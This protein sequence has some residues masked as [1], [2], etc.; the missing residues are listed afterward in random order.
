MQSLIKIEWLKIKKYPAFWWM[1]IIVALTYPG[2]NYMFHNIYE[3]II[4]R[5][6]MAG[7]VAKFLLGNPFSF[8]DAWHSVA[9]FSSFFVIVPALLII[10]LVSNEYTYKTHRQ[11][12]IDGWSRSQFINAKMIDVFIISFIVTLSFTIV[13]AIFGFYFSDAVRVTRWAE[14]LQYIPLFFLQ[15]FAQLSWAF[16][17]AFLIKRA[18]IALGI[19]VFYSLIIE[20]I[21]KGYF[22]FREWGV[23]E[24]F[25]FEISNRLLPMP[26]FLGKIDAASNEAY[27]KTLV[28]INWHILYTL[29][30]TSAI[31]WLCY[32]INK[33]RDL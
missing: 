26:N 17:L 5:K 3:Q 23:R 18:F 14:E 9:Y 11:N 4:G 30:L 13:A 20:N 31:W 16:L 2:I 27:K 8:P 19:F 24:F 6:D 7:N 12:I 28:D 32:A 10:M 29:I 15:T 25:P 33:K 21:I 22:K 1:L